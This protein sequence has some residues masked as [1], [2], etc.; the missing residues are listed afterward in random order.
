MINF[1]NRPQQR[2]ATEQAD[3]GRPQYAGRSCRKAF[4]A[5]LLNMTGFELASDTR[6]CGK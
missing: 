3:H 1:I 5:M 2:R 6:L 4:E